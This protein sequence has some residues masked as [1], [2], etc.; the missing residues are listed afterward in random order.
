MAS[1]YRFLAT[2][3]HPAAR[4]ARGLH[5]GMRNLTLPAPRVVVRPMLWA[6][7][8]ARSLY[9]FGMRVFLCEPLFKA[10]CAR[11]GRG[12]RT[13]VYIHFIQGKG[14]IIL[15]DDVIVDGKCCF[16]FASRVSVRPTLSIGDHSGVGHNCHFSVAKRID[17]G[18]HCRIA[19]DV[20][21]FDSPGHPSDPEPRRLGRP[22]GDGDVRPIVVGDNVWIGGRS[23]IFPGVTIG[24]GSIVSAGSVVLGDIPP[25]TVVAGNPARRIAS[26]KEGV[27]TRI[28]Q[29]TPA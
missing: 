2:S 13:D 28:G 25:F 7:L 11:Y 14:D 5:R 10:S 8:T 24:E 3:D 29:P 17:I 15:G 1:V 22:P 21:M 12:V 20:W 18:R 27:S 16:H 23:I 19:S 4:A 26:L 6:F 9:Y